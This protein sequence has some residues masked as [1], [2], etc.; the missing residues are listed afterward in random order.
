MASEAWTVEY[1]REK[2]AMWLQAEEDCAA[3]AGFAI[4]G[5]QWT[6]ADLNTI[7][8]RIDFWR[9]EVARLENGSKPGIR[10]YQIIP[11]G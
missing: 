1:A 3:G 7:A 4:D 2:L 8:R 9:R 6:S 10:A 5:Q 11:R